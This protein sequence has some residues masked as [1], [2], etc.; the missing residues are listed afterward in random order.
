M[1]YLVSELLSEGLA[2]VDGNNGSLKKYI[3]FAAQILRFRLISIVS[4]MMNH[5]LSAYRGL[6]VLAILFTVGASTVAQSVKIK[7][8]GTSLTVSVNGSAS[9]N[10]EMLPDGGDGTTLSV[11]SGSVVEIT[12]TPK[13]LRIRN[14]SIAKLDLSNAPSSLIQ[15]IS[16]GTELESVD[17]SGATSLKSLWLSEYKTLQTV[18]LSPLS[19][20]VQ[21]YLGRYRDD[22]LQRSLRDVTFPTI[23]NI[24]TLVLH[25]VSIPRVDFSTFTELNDLNIAGGGAHSFTQD[26]TFPNSPNLEKVNLWRL[27][28]S[29]NI[30]VSHN[31]KLKSFVY[32]GSDNVRSIKISGVEALTK[33]EMQQADG[34]TLPPNLR[35]INLSGNGLTTVTSSVGNG[36]LSSPGVRVVDISNNRFSSAEIDQIISRLPNGD[37]SGEFVFAGVQ[38]PTDGNQFTEAHKNALV[39]KGWVVGFPLSVGGVDYYEARIY[40]T[41]TS[42][43]VYVEGVQ[44]NAEVSVLSASGALVLSAD[45]DAQGRAE[46]SLVGKPSG[47]YFV[48]VGSTKQRVVLR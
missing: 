39:A 24:K 38:T 29:G 19:N 21:L 5:V 40:P 35:V 28:Y 42:E 45:T 25:E 41:V 18:D 44:P 32:T 23:N 8:K 22:H 26:W 16:E 17:L 12:G 20:L 11:E 34:W 6:L 46:L 36:L 1:M 7:M 47:V 15:L 14:G 3:T 37:G 31:P 9:V 30:D 48:T 10:G 4:I 43:V 27:R 33:L 2:M 13:Q